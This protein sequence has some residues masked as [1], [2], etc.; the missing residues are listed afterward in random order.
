MRLNILKTTSRTLVL[1]ASS[2]G[3]VG[4]YG[5]KLPGTGAAVGPLLDALAPH[6]GEL[7]SKLP[8]EMF[9]RFDRRRKLSADQVKAIRASTEK[10]VTLAHDYSL[11][12]G[13]VSMVKRRM[14]Y[15]WV[16]S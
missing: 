12:L 4:R 15:K 2:C 7:I 6:L 10:L 14:L 13:M 1:L 11:S 16:I 8:P 9:R 5:A 3:F